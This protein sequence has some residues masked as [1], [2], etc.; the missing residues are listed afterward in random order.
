MK[1]YRTILN[2]VILAL[3]GYYLFLVPLPTVCDTTTTYRIGNLDRQFNLTEDQFKEDLQQATDI[4]NGLTRRQ[5]F[6]YDPKSELTVN[7][8]FDERQSLSDKIQSAE[9]DT[10]KSKGELES[11]LAEHT[12][13]STEFEARL[14]A[15]NDQI[16]EWNARG[17]APEEVYN[18]LKEEEVILQKEANDLNTMASEL[19][20]NVGDYNAKVDDINQ[21]ENTL[22]QVLHNKPEAGLYDPK[23]NRIDIY[24]NTSK[25]ELLH[26]LEHEFGHALGLKHVTD[27][28][29]I[30]FSK[31]SLL[32]RPTQDD[33]DELKKACRKMTPVEK[34]QDVLKSA[35]E[36]MDQSTLQ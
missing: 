10:L 31:S 12:R 30:M 25:E 20:L 35:R 14:K 4:W 15:L 2:L 13:R 26:T 7:L 3:A 11:K 17:G 9:E 34:L 24:F 1:A 16:D 5:L 8:V 22:S 6:K 23:N 36:N 21:T 32:T 27:P 28:K 19:N 18:K 29:A 33:V